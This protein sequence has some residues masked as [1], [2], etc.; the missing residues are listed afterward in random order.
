MS[1]PIEATEVSARFRPASEVESLTFTSGTI[2]RLV[3]PGSATNGQ[4]GLFEW[5][6]PAATGGAGPHIH[7]KISES[8]FVTAGRVRLYNGEKWVTASQGDF[9]YVP[10]R[11]VHGFK[12]DFDEPASMLILFSP[13]EPRE[14]YFR[15]LI[16]NAASGR[17]LSPQER[18]EFLARH[19]QYDA[20]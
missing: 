9:L 5:N 12:N 2:A 10:E 14:Q 19:D 18:A 16:A 13:G 7:K 1:Y 17:K 8:F 6:M 20:G 11:G 4:F 15:E 3:G